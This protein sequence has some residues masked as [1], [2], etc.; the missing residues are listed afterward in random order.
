MAES[1]QFY[2]LKAPGLP[3]SQSQHLLSRIVKAF[4][5]P[6]AGCTPNNKPCNAIQFLAPQLNSGLTKAESVLS[7]SSETTAKAFLTSLATLTKEGGNDAS[8]S[9]SGEGIDVVR[10]QQHIDTF[11][12][13]KAL[14]AIQQK[15][16]KMN[17]VGVKASILSSDY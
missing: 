17:R 14:P 8:V 15:L 10:P 13:L 11:D 12:L 9:F 5:S 3:V 4:A 7:S 2:F 16:S 1:P 6:T